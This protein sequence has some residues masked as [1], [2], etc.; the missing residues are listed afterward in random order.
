MCHEHNFGAFLYPS[1][2]YVDAKLYE[3]ANDQS[4]RAPVRSF[5]SKE[6]SFLNKEKVKR[7]LERIADDPTSVSKS[8][9]DIY[10]IIKKKVN[11]GDTGVSDTV[12]EGN[13]DWIMGWIMSQLRLRDFQGMVPVVLGASGDKG[14]PTVFVQKHKQNQ[15]GTAH[16]PHQSDYI[17]W[18]KSGKGESTNM[19]GSEEAANANAW[20]QSRTEDF[21]DDNGLSYADRIRTFAFCI[22]GHFLRE[23]C[24][25]TDLKLKLADSSE[26]SVTGASVGKA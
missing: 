15:N 9:D 7:V 26:V 12:T 24:L 20:L 11:A 16:V 8:A 2:R 3:R 5:S 4:E 1:C 14:S 22:L 6:T 23:V 10:N 19:I 17:P 25:E 21:P 13:K 18:L